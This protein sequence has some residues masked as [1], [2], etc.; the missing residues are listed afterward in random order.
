[1]NR[2]QDLCFHHQQ[3]LSV[4]IKWDSSTR[5]P[6]PFRFL[7]WS[8]LKAMRHLWDVLVVWTEQAEGFFRFQQQQQKKKRFSNSQYMRTKRTFRVFACKHNTVGMRKSERLVSIRRSTIL[9]LLA[10]LSIVVQRKRRSTV[11]KTS[12]HNNNTG[13]LKQNLLQKQKENKVNGLWSWLEL[14]SS[15]LTARLDWIVLCT[16]DCLPGWLRFP[17]LFHF[18]SFLSFALLSFA[19]LFSLSLIF[20][21]I[22]LFHWHVIKKRERTIR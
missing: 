11:F 3:E 22:S 9:Y 8:L 7:L 14:N 4:S 19:S 21:H 1:M 13:C 18:P 2:S 5:I 10:L 6:V 17:P 20:F 16:L 12:T 15:L